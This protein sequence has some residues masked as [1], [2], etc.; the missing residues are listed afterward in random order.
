M[1]EYAKE[2]TSAGFSVI[3]V[4][5]PLTGGTGKQPSTQWMAYQ[6][7]I[8]TEDELK[9]WFDSG[10]QSNIGIVTGEVSDLV[11]IDF[12]TVNAY[13]LALAVSNA[14]RLTAQVS[15][16]RG[17]HCY[18]RPDTT[19]PYKTSPFKLDGVTNHI[20]AEG[21]FVVAPPSLHANGNTYKFTNDLQ[22][23]LTIDMAEIGEA[24]AQA[25][26]LFTS[27]VDATSKPS[28]WASELMEPIGEG[29]RN[30]RAAQLCGLLIN[31]FPYD[32][33]LIGGLMHAWNMT[34]CNPPLSKQEL[35]SVVDGEY[36]R[37]GPERQDR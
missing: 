25:G 21:G 29:G 6:K 13:E 12:D 3:P 8:A 11:V 14:F 33:G 10:T 28:Q 32:K 2:Y 23:I 20:K 31:K 7:R 36:A 1:L 30:T 16:G 37:Y 19:R 34:Y 18:F 4:S 17:V 9:L 27:K 24:L 5:S 35:A 22:K 26:A 15:T